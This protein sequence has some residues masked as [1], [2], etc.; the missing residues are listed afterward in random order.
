MLP[1]HL[2]D[3]L[4]F[5][6]FFFMNMKYLFAFLR[7]LILV[8]LVFF[9]ACSKKQ[10]ERRLPPEMPVVEVYKSAIPIVEEF[11]GQ[12][13]GY[14]DISIRA[15]VEGYLSGVH[16]E[17]GSRV[18]KGQLLYSI[19]SAPFDA[20]VA[21]AVSRVA[22]AKTRLVQA[23][24]DYNRIKPLAEERAVSQSDLD[25]AFATLGAA[26]AA[27]EAA[28]AQLNYAKIELGYTRIKSP[29][30]GII[31]RT[32]A[33]ASEFV[34]RSPNPVVLNVVSRLDTILVQFTLSEMKYLQFLEY[35]SDNQDV[36]KG[37][38][39]GKRDIELVFADNSVH[40]Y[41]GKLDF[42]DRNID[43]MMGTIML[44]A[45]FPNPD[46]TA[47]PG[48]FAKVK[49]VVDEEMER[50]VVPQRSLQELQGKF[51]VLVVNGDNI[52]TFREV[53]VGAAYGDLRI[54]RSG[55]KVGERILLEGFTQ[56]GSGMAIRPQLQFFDS[57]T[58][59][60]E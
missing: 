4:D 46:F 39:G 3:F 60:V 14:F 53:E 34:G 49:L 32:Q 26:K 24:G 8:F 20:K 47:R 22:E 13:Y 40:P 18:K 55:L 12:T 44:Q 10:S 37:F 29:I 43:P 35:A 42:I 7:P 9:A 51:S 54:I 50:I 17:E 15:R 58:K 59:V 11:V 57:V 2:K 5:M 28:E 19:D 48:L 45:S 25:A 27:V 38:S 41:P 56:V 23:Q 30:S 1:L 52:L 33:K 6:L 31:G 36:Y 21:E 16:F